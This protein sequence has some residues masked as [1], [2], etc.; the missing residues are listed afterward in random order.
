MVESLVTVLLQC[1][2]DS[3]TEA[4]LKIGQYLMKLSRVKLRR[5]KQCATFFGPPFTVVIAS[6]RHA[7]ASHVTVILHD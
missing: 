3:D 1:S 7:R 2:P 6:E 4:S 5:T